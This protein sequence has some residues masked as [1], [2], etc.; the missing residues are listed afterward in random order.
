MADMLCRTKG[1]TSPKGKPRVYFTCHPGDFDRYFETVCSHIFKTHDCA[2][3]CTGDM[4]REIPEQDRVTD[5]ES[6]S[7]FV[8]PVTFKLLSEPNRAMDEDFPYAVEHH[9]PVLPLMMEPGLDALYARPDRFGQLQYLNLCSTDTTEISYEE[10]LKKYLESVLIGDELAARV[11][12]AFDAYIFLSYRK[13][14]RRY[15]NELMRMI[16]RYPQCRDIAIW[17]DEFLTPGENFRESIDKILENSRLFALLVTPNLLEEPEG[18]P[19]FVMGEEYPAARRAGIDVLPAEMVE[20]DKDTLREKFQDIPPCVDPRDDDAFR[21]RLLET[22]SR[23]ARTAN[24]GDPVHNY[25]IG[26]AYL[27]GIDVEVDRRRALELITGAAEQNL[28]EAMEKLYHMYD[29]G[30]GTGLN[31]REAARWAEQVT[32]YCRQQYGEAHSDTLVWMSNTAAA[33]TNLGEYKKAKT[34]TEHAFELNCRIHGE[35]H[36]NSLGLLS[37]LAVICF[38]LGEFQKSTALI[39]KT[40]TLCCSHLGEDHPYTLTLLN[41]LASFCNDLDD[42]QKALELNKKAYTLRCSTLGEEHPD[43][44]ITLSNLAAAY[45]GAGDFQKALELNEKA[46]TLFCKILREDHPS[47]LI[48]LSNLAFTHGILGNAQQELELTERAYAL[49]CKVLGENHPDTVAILSELSS[50]YDSRGSQQKALE[51]YRKLYALRCK[52]LGENHPDTLTALNKLALT[53]DELGDLQAAL[54]LYEKVFAQRWSV[55]GENHPDTLTSINNLA[56][57]YDDLGN[58]QNA[59]ILY[60][61]MYELQ[62]TSLGEEDPD[63]LATL[64]RLALACYSL[65]DYPR[66]AALMEQ[67]YIAR[68]KVLGPGHPETLAALENLNAIKHSQQAQDKPMSKWR[69]WLGGQKGK[70]RQP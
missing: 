54:E 10:K 51:A 27:D 11:R 7:L 60:E 2:V 64:S 25:L 32:E 28:P 58:Y 4:T 67:V 40:Y 43:T 19:N 5:L 20:T 62:C 22:V 55:L 38:H 33:Y 1:N 66:S 41:N 8:I 53:H 26:L 16:H 39:E 63:T 57:I 70:D 3:F 24:D 14:D 61:K 65:A 59:R 21:A 34:L 56:L 17:Y 69:K 47:T 18:R 9:I 52:T 42:K 35:T 36:S 12:A 13:K 30:T 23:L 15:A 37:N 31:Y 45:C 50:V 44:L 68:Q 6:H 29:T 48:A 46:Y 49:R